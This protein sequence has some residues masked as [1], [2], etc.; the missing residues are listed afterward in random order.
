MGAMM[1]EFAMPVN[2]ILCWSASDLSSAIRQR[3]VSC[4]EVMQ[5]TLARID[6]V[7]P[8][9]NAIVSR[10]DAKQLLQQ[11]DARDAQ[12]A[13][14]QSMGWLHGMPLA[15]KDLAP[16]A[17]I[18]NTMGSPLLQT[19]V[20]KEDG[21]LVQ[22]MKAAGCIVIGKTNVPEFGLGS[23]T[24][25][26]VF[27]ATGNA[28]DPGKSAGGSSGGAAVAL[29]SRMLALADGSD[30]MGSL[31]NPAAWNNIFGLRPSQGRVPMWPAQDVWLS[32][33][34][35]EGPMARTVPDLA[36]LLAVQAGW[37]A[38]APLSIAQSGEQFNGDLQADCKGQRIGWLGD[39]DGYLALEPG[40][41]EVCGQGLQRLQTIGCE[42]E[43]VR[44]AM[45]PQRVWDCWL[46]WR[47]ALVAARIAPF[48]LQPKNRALIKPE[49]LWE[50]DQGSRLTGPELLS[51]SITR[52]QLYQQLLQLF[53]QVDFLALPTA[54]VWPF[55]VTQRWPAAIAGRAMDTYH[56]WMEVVIL[57]T[58]AGL[59]CIS[60]PV[61]FNAAGLPMGMQIIGKPRDDWGLLQLAHAYE[62][63]A[64]DV[65][66]VM[67]GL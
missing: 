6:A 66:R 48:L 41:L 61:G 38:R 62:Q 64:Q 59:P 7:N 55:D 8:R 33:L 51:A 13:R 67:P 31:R 37:D 57:P 10:V 21:L 53:E 24:F 9:L 60:V 35:T 23:H 1:A 65:L 42:V 2:S 45:A 43:P 26:E 27:G 22:R 40:I 49:A 19:F 58:L 20:P 5:A 14:G 47:R 29:A 12:L 11:A 16:C 54:Q 44:L 28:F 32:Q 52:T 3:R 46:V 39:L 63:A 50:H 4:R 15:V 30:F 56:R 34:G 25:N 18:A 36:R 17:G